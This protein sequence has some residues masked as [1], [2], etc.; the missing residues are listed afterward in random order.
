MR[1]RAR[2]LWMALLVVVWGYA[3]VAGPGRRPAPG[4]ET[5]LWLAVESGA[6]DHDFVYGP[7][8]LERF[9]KRFGGAPES[10]LTQREGDAKR[11]DTPWLWT[12]LA[13]TARRIAGAHGTF[14]FQGALVVLALLLAQ[15]TLAPRLGETSAALLG[16][17]ALFGSVLFRVPARLEPHALDWLAMAIA[18]W[19]TWQRRSAPGGPAGDV[20]RGELRARPGLWRGWTAGL[21]FGVV[22]AGSPTYL[23]LALPLVAAAPR[24]RRWTR[25]ALFVV[26]TL[27]V[28]TAIALAGWALWDPISTVFGGGLFAWSA[29]G[30]LLGRGVG[31]V[32][33]FL[34]VLLLVV[35]G[36]RSEGRRWVLTAVAATLALQV[37]LLPFDFVEGSSGVGNA[38]FLA[39]YALLLLAVEHAESRAWTLSPLVLSA[40]FLLP[41]WL[42]PF[43]GS[44]VRQAERWTDP[45]TSRLPIASTLRA[46]PGSPEL[47]RTGLVVRG[48]APGIAQSSGGGLRLLARRG[49]ILVVSDHALSS[50]R[51]ELGANAPSAIAVEGGT[52]G[53][54]TFRPDGEVAFDVAVSARSARRHPVWWSLSGAWIYSLEI[55]LGK[56]PGAPISLDVP[57]GRAVVPAA[58][59]I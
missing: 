39:P 40:V 50:V 27:A 2:W 48:V 45:V 43:G 13:A 36:G 49:T 7:A 58:G 34:P 29:I 12:R 11:F 52:L 30:L 51:I 24:E 1:R 18:G 38:W 35:S 32:P 26:A 33:Y 44:V 22:L 59:E 46:A 47:V 54:T 5:T 19:A 16:G 10:V 21:A 9:E 56:A 14:A 4:R 31:V 17:V 25:L 41:A 23:P 55:E 57:F 6:V 28:L 37:L 42:A 8:D 20:Y 15:L 53:N 3:V